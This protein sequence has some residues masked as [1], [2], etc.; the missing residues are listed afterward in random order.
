MELSRDRIG[1][2]RAGAGAGAVGALLLACSAC[3]APLLA[4]VLAWLGVAGVSLMG[5]VG[6][7]AAAIGAVALAWMALARRRRRFPADDSGNSACQNQAMACTSSRADANDG[8]GGCG[9]R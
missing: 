7:V 9:C 1:M 5:P 6:V 2:A 3:C 4:P 8:G